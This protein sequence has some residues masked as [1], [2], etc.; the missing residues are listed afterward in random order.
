MRN[1]HGDTNSWNHIQAPKCGLLILPV[2]QGVGRG[3]PHRL[4]LLLIVPSVEV[5][6]CGDGSLEL[7][8]REVEAGDVEGC[9]ILWDLTSK[10]VVGE[11]QHIQVLQSTEATLRNCAI[12]P[13]VRQVNSS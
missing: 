13:V 9:E 3:S 10:L 2:L 5:I 8:A 6:S 12:E 1:D 4:E 11:V 7:V